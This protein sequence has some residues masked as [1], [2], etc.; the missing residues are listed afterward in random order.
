MQLA[1]SPDTIGGAVGSGPP[2]P[3]GTRLRPYLAAG[4]AIVG[5]SLIAVT[6]VTAPPPDVQH[7]RIQL[8]DYDEFG[9]SQLTTTTEANWSGLESVL[10]S[11]SNWLTAPDISHGHQ[12]RPPER[13]VSGLA[14]TRRNFIWKIGHFSAW[15]QLQC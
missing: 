2:S 4:V 15:S 3:A 9:L 7:R 14:K 5:A 1:L 12:Y 6:P 13:R 10:S 11:S 8:V